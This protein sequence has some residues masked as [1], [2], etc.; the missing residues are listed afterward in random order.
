[1]RYFVFLAAAFSL[2]LFAPTVEAQ[3]IQ[4]S[5]YLEIARIVTDMQ[6]GNT[7]ASVTLQS[8]N[9]N[10]IILP[11]DLVE[12][13]TENS[14]VNSVFLT[15][16]TECILGVGDESCLRINVKRDASWPGI[17]AIHQGARE[18]GDSIVG[19][20]NSAFDVNATFHSIYVHSESDAIIGIAPPGTIT[21]AYTMPVKSS[22][23]M[24][25]KILPVFA[26]GIRNSGGFHNAVSDITE[27]QNSAA[28][29][30]AIKVEEGIL[31]QAIVDHAYVADQVETLFPITMLGV[32]KLETSRYFDDGFYPLNSILQIIVIGSQDSVYSKPDQLQLHTREGFTLPVS[33]DIAGWVIDQRDNVTDAKYIFGIDKVANS[34]DVSISFAMPDE[35]REESITMPDESREEPITMPDESREEPITM[36]GKLGE[37]PVTEQTSAYWPWILFAIIP[38][39]GVAA[40]AYILKKRI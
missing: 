6:T 11:K 31:M 38:I 24:Y 13:I 12:S 22:A 28:S 9:V 14:A 39:A 21:I 34:K 18:I 30:A 1:M 23:D 19:K 20:V 32:T 35:S 5:S 4:F 29:F 27:Y 15:S 10:D 7:S 3:D 25:E 26:E 8:T 2:I 40:L 33:F 37:E 36:P 17:N 16:K